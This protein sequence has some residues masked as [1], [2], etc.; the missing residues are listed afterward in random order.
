[1]ARAPARRAGAPTHPQFSQ[2]FPA[3]PG[4]HD[5]RLGSVQSHVRPSQ[6]HP[7]T[8]ARPALATGTRAP[9]D[10]LPGA[11]AGLTALG[12]RDRPQ[13]CCSAA[14]VSLA[15]RRRRKNEGALN[16]AGAGVVRSLR[17]R[18][19]ARC[20][21]APRHPA[22]WLR[23][24]GLQRRAHLRAVE[25]REVTERFRSLPRRRR[26][27]APQQSERERSSWYRHTRRRSSSR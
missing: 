22:S 23:W 18:E 2:H 19:L 20:G 10:R 1:M 21:H 27:S 24:N 9:F 4:R 6:P 12:R 15:K 8:L 3:P 26:V 7:S 14:I 16:E 5:P 11:R 17:A 13:R 25:R